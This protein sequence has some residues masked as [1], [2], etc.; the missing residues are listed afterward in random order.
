MKYLRVLACF[1]CALQILLIGCGRQ[2]CTA[3]SLNADLSA[4]VEPSQVPA[5]QSDAK[6]AA[7]GVTR[8]ALNDFS[9]V[10][11]NRLWAVGRE[12]PAPSKE[13]N[14]LITSADGGRTWRRQW[15]GAQEWCYRV[16]FIN[17]QVG[18]MVGYEGLVLKS[19]DG[20]NSWNKRR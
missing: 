18:W 8:F 4:A 16:R 19:T 7:F 12:R 3:R 5:Q 10:G 15:G 9:E 2:F 11:G 13:Q 17:S 6:P 14:L 20:G 1:T